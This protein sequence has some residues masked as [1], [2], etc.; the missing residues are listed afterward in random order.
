MA[1]EKPFDFSPFSNLERDSLQMLI[2]KSLRIQLIEEKTGRKMESE[3][4]EFD[5]LLADLQATDGF[6]N[7][8]QGNLEDAIAQ[9]VNRVRNLRPKSP[10]FL[11]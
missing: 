6:D 10:I 11:C 3:R 1:E 9:E 7:K 2:D 8:F 5:A 4:A